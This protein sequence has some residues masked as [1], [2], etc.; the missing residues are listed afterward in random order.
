MDTSATRKAGQRAQRRQERTEATQAP[1]RGKVPKQARAKRSREMW[2]GRVITTLGLVGIALT[3]IGVSTSGEPSIGMMLF[4]IGLIV[5]GII[6]RKLEQILS[7]LRRSART[8][9]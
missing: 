8:Y 2:S 9:D 1:G 4:S 5:S 3:I 6:I 7:E